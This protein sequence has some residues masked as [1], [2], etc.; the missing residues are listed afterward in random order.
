M[1]KALQGNSSDTIARWVGNTPEVIRKHYIDKLALE[2]L[3]PS[4]I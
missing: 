2:H 4:D 3:K 1:S